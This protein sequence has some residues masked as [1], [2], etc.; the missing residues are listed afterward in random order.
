MKMPA[1]V[2]RPQKGDVGDRS[3]RWQAIAWCSFASLS[4]AV[5]AIVFTG[6][7]IFITIV[8]AGMFGYVAGSLIA[9]LSGQA[10]DTFVHTLLAGRGE[11]RAP[12]YSAQ[13]ALLIQGRIVEAIKSFHSYIASHPEDLDVRIRLAEVLG[14]EGNDLVGSEEMYLEARI[15]GTSKRQD[16]SVSN[17]LIDLYRRTGEREKLKAELGRFARNHPGTVEARNAQAFLRQL[18]T[19]EV[20]Q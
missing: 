16:V 9:W 3:A 5:A 14:K 8:A 2:S 11:P 1:A 19:E 17:G 4:M 13:E 10:S 15:V 18:A 7:P 6:A 20:H 12:E